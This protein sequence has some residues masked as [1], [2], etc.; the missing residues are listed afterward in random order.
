[1]QFQLGAALLQ[2]CVLAILSRQDAYGYHLTQQVQQV[3][4]IS[5]SSLYPVLRRL[6]K[7]LCLTT[8]DQPVDGR[9]RRYYSIT[10]KGRTLCDQYRTQWQQYKDKVD[11]IL[12]SNQKEEEQQ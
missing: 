10:E 11:S 8:Y 2:T 6:E 9:N 3:M 7:E 4:T 1:M 12:N 5:E